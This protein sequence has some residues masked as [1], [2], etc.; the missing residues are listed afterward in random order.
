MRDRSPK[1]KP[2]QTMPIAVDLVQQQ[3][4]QKRDTSRS[5]YI[6][7]HITSRLLMNVSAI[8]VGMVEKLAALY[9]SIGYL[10]SRK[11][12]FLKWFNHNLSTTNTLILLLYEKRFVNKYV[13]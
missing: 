5:K 10:E 1:S 9:R 2:S 7:T 3:Q 8:A 13:I 6:P 12:G 11:N 4:Q